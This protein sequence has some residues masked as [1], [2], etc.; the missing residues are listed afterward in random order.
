MK[1][2]PRSRLAFEWDP[3]ITPSALDRDTE[4]LLRAALGRRGRGAAA[5]AFL[6]DASFELGSWA[7]SHLRNGSAMR[8]QALDLARAADALRRQ[9]ERPSGRLRSIIHAFYRERWYFAKERPAASF[10]PDAMADLDALLDM[11]GGAAED[12]A[13]ALALDRGHKHSDA[14]A[15]ARRTVLARI[16]ERHFPGVSTAHARGPFGKVLATLRD[17]GLMD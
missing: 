15:L 6:R 5:D 7:V 9:L 8:D 17:R 10:L 12:A 4:R 16:F 3:S 11:V 13:Q 14:D 2:P 1:T